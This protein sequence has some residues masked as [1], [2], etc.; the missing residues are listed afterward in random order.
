M[1]HDGLFQDL[2]RTAR[3]AYRASPEMEAFRP[4]PDDIR[5]QAVVPNHCPCSDVFR[6]DA[7]LSSQKHPE[8][9]AAIRAAGEIAHWRATYQDTDI[10]REFKDRF[11]CYCIIGENGPFSS[12]ALRLY[13]VYMPAHF[14]YPWHHHPAEE[15][16]M[17]V[18]GRATFMRRG[19]PDEA[20]SEGRTS[21]H[22]SDQPHAMETLTDPVLCL[23]AWRNQ[24]QT[25]PVLTD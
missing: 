22:E 8:L 16:Y 2:L 6:D 1:T 11:G 18:S 24:F 12:D 5:R 4:F 14:Y 9:Q 17:V 20:L 25:P 21:F 15:I 3:D 13:M 19:Q 7:A 10:G 23:V